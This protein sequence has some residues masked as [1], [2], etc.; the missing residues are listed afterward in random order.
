M[1]IR[2]AVAISLT[3]LAAPALAQ[4]G[5]PLK[6]ART[7]D[8][9]VSSG[10]WMSLA[11]SPDGRTILFDMLGEL[12]ALP[13]EGGRARPIAQGLAFDVQ[14]VFSPD[15]KWIAFVSDRSGVDDVWIARADGKGARK[16]STGDEGTVRTSPEWS[17]DGKSVYVSRHR[18]ALGHNELWR[19]DIAGGPAEL[20]V[21][22]RKDAS[23]PRANW[24]STLGVSPSRD[25]K[26]L[27]YARRVGD[28]SFDEPVGWT[29]VRRDIGTGAEE[30]IVS[31]SG[32]REAGVE[33]FFRPA[34][35]PD[36]KLLAYATRQM[37]RT[38]LRVRDLT[39]GEDR[40]LGAAPLDLMN[41]ASWM[42]LIPRYAFTP[43]G[44][45][46]LIAVDGKVERRP[47]DGSAVTRIPFTA[48]LQ[49]A[50]GPST[51][52]R[53]REETGVV[54]AKLPQGTTPSPDGKQVAY[55]ALG[56]VYVQP[57]DGGPSLRL[58][59]AG[60]PPSLPNWSPDGTQIVYVTWSEGA[61]GAV[62][63]IAADGQSAPVKLS[64]VAAFYTHPAF[65]P[66]GATVLAVRSPAAARQ[67]TSFEFGTVRPAE[68]VAIPAAG[69]APRVVTRGRLGQKPHFVNG[70]PGTAYLL[71]GDGLSAVD[72]ASG[73]TR[74]VAA[75]K[76]APYYF[77]ETLANADDLR[78]SPDGKWIAA[79]TSEQLF[80][81]P[82]PADPKAVV[83]LDAPDK[84]GRKVTDMGA[85]F[86][87]WR[88]DGSLIWSVGNFL[89]TIPNATAPVPKSHVEL[90][91]ELPRVR[92]TGSIL[93]RGA[94]ALTMAG[95]DKVIEDADILITGDRIAGIGARGSLK[96]PA[97]T[98]ER[99]LNGKTVTPGFIDDHDHIGG[100]RRNV[101]GYE[102]W[103]L[104]ARLAFG[105]TTSFDPSTLGI[106]QVA[107]QDLIDAGLVVGPRLRSTGP[108]LFSKERFTSLD[109]VRGVLRR[110]RDAWGLRNIKQYR[111]ESRTVRQWI[112]IAA[113]ELGLLPTTEGSHNAKLMLTQTIDGYAGNE[114]ALPIAPFQEDV[115]GLYQRMRTSYVSTLLVN[116]SGPAAEN[117]FIAKYDPALDAKVK[118]FWSPSAIAHKLAHVEWGSLDASRM[119]ALAA[120]AARLAANG[121]L[122]GMGSHGDHPG[123]GYHSEMEA[124]ATG[125]MTPLA[126]LHAA[127]AGA[128]ETIGR[129]DDMG[130]LEVGKYADL[131]V[132]DADPVADIRNSKSVKLVM[133]G[134]QL[135][136]ADTLDELWPVQ[137]KLP[138]PWFAQDKPAQWLPAK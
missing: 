105:V 21:G 65:T 66:D 72:L 54:R 8:Y 111:G 5:L 22:I 23:V 40:D 102:E 86:F 133:R 53:F 51:R 134:G 56:S 126:I 29:I 127:T 94:R 62:W 30:T 113:K 16:I 109:Q 119:P 67:Q 96:V 83:N 118:R 104:R 95:G 81:L 99:E 69:G 77:T 3:A 4:G 20:I 108:A 100:V 59:V 132:F 87:N 98:P 89:Q 1:M 28:M 84:P 76:G 137:R 15:G 117:Y 93:L 49:L 135:F 48:R 75:V 128:A 131:V 73:A 47:V 17:A 50:V 90:V 120:D 38:R 32:G 26:Y 9:E 71:T 2:A 35:S 36:G 6:P 101:I 123:I 31:N 103:G 34:I 13:A 92:P 63:R 19:H 125:G 14:P 82:T 37:N 79:Q 70:Q 112:A 121:A 64:D 58:P 91:A 11:V 88:A 60:D 138:A 80:V 25:G 24:Q 43:D 115:I 107:Y 18:I 46:I 114:H 12:Y 110:Y 106:D 136:D 85:D 42:D 116:T 124:H 78:I 39:T 45:A 52:I 68:L 10:T 129:L 61:G 7:L 57:V 74:L 27:Y 122:V 97:G 44:T 33:T 41:G 55:A 130:T